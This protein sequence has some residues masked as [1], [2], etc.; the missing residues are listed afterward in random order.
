MSTVIPIA[1]PAN[2]AGAQRIESVRSIIREQQQDADAAEHV[3]AALANQHTV[4]AAYDNGVLQ[5]KGEGWR[6]GFHT[7]TWWGILL[8]AI[9]TI[10]ALGTI[11]VLLMQLIGRHTPTF[12]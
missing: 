12:G 2:H 6:D 3:A 5:G 8:G 4:R 10:V 11:G 1:F 9:G 7:G